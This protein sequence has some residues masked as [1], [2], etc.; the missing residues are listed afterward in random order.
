L[1]GVVARVMVL[2]MKIVVT[3]GMCGY[4]GF[5]LVMQRG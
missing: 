2:L 5:G 3:L 4:L 1:A